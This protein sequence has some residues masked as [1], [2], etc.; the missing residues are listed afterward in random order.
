MID[1]LLSFIG[2]SR[3]SRV[4]RVRVLGIRVDLINRI[5]RVVRR[6]RKAQIGLLVVT[7]FAISAAIAPEVAP[8]D[9]QSQQ[10]GIIQ[11][12]E[13][14]GAN[15]LGTDSYGRDMLSRLMYG[16]RTSLAVGIGAVVFGA[17]LGITIGLVSGYFGGWIDD[18]LMRFVDALWA[19]P[20]LLIAIMLT[21]IRGPGFWNVIIAIGVA[22][23]D[24]FARIVR[25]EVLVIREEEYTLAARSIG[26][27]SFPIIFFE[28]L[29]N[30]VGPII[31]QF[32][33]RLARAIL[34][35]STLSF[36]GIG[37]KPST[38]T[39]G[40]MLGQGRDFLVS[41]PW[42]SILPGLCITITILGVNLFGD[43][44]RD[45]FDV[46]ESID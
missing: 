23:I 19:L 5:G 27:G 33:I 28:V 22:N 11:P 41:A 30:T 8:Y 13:M 10:F 18:A 16:A 14:T 43:A 34:A 3:L 1:K 37:V 15:P 4:D 6:D 25:G 46:R 9:P 20:W 21:V 17:V 45:A 44:L 42:I 38:A 31:V 35:E 24:D 36:L 32:T 39:W 29:P 40:A 12:P 2:I 26:M 7:L